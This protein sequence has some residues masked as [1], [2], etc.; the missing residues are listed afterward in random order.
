MPFTARVRATGELFYATSE[1][2]GDFES[3]RDTFLL[4]NGKSYAGRL[5]VGTRQIRET[6]NTAVYLYTSVKPTTFKAEELD[7]VLQAHIRVIRSGQSSQ[8]LSSQR[9]VA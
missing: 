8:L 6:Y 3:F 2:E 7:R 4:A 9:F 1:W 5:L